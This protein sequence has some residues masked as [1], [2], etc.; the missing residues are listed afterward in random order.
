M[1]WEVAKA[2]EYCPEKLHSEDMD[3]KAGPW[4]VVRPSGHNYGQGYNPRSMS[5]IWCA[6]QASLCQSHIYTVLKLL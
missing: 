6:L 4:L 1:E 3:T 5:S 2:C